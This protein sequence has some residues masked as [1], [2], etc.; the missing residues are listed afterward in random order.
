VHPAAD[1]VLRQS[2]APLDRDLVKAGEAPIDGAR[3]LHIDG[4]LVGAD[5][6]ATMLPAGAAVT[7]QFAP[8]QFFELSDDERL[9]G[10]QFESLPSGVQVSAG[11][12]AW[13][14]TATLADSIEEI[15]IDADDRA[16]AV[17]QPL[18]IVGMVAVDA[19]MRNQ[20]LVSRGRGVLGVGVKEASW[21]MASSV[22]ATAAGPV[23][24]TKRYSTWIDAISSSE[25]TAPTASG[26]RRFAVSAGEVTG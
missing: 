9:T 1:L 24:S 14:G 21:A 13:G 18:G 12:T 7:D 17:I 10:P 6:V 22:D 15:V 3:R 26:A 25:A 8:S 16:T 20:G 2:V 23:A 4:V 11:A 5:N 19:V